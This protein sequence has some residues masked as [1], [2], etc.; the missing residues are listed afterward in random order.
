MRQEFEAELHAARN[1]VYKAQEA[2]ASTEERVR[3]SE[4]AERARLTLEYETRIKSMATEIE[5][6][7]EELRSR[8]ATMHEELEKY[9]HAVSTSVMDTTA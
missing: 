8:S 7:R 4:A 1:E 3:L 6:L 9:E 5:R 2:L